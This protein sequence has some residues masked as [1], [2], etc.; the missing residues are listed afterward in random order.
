M[1]SSIS[2]VNLDPR[3]F[4]P[5]SESR[6]WMLL[7]YFLSVSIWSNSSSTTNLGVI[8]TEFFVVCALTRMLNWE[9]VDIKMSIFF[10]SMKLMKNCSDSKFC[11]TWGYILLVVKVVAK[12][13]S[14][15]DL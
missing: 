2:S 13:S 4:A 8:E 15:V 9:G 1:R 12:R 5:K 10:Q 3:A 14:A 11:I 6:F 7:K